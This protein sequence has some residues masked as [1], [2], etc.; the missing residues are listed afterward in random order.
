MRPLENRKSAKKNSYGR[1]SLFN[2][3][4]EPGTQPSMHGDNN[5][6][7]QGSCGYGWDVQKESE[8]EEGGLD[9]SDHGSRNS[10]EGSKGRDH[11]R[12]INHG[13]QS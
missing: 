1:A 10:H 2:E 6:S 5:K 11:G 13:R 9:A 12:D 8:K 7:R 4:V 3:S